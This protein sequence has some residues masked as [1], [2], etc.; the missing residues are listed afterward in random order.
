MRGGAGIEI[1][2]NGSYEFGCVQ[3]C[4]IR[5]AVVQSALCCLGPAYNSELLLKVCG[6]DG[7]HRAVAGRGRRSHGEI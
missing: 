5:E 1:L 6:L 2:A 7:V 4:P 3:A